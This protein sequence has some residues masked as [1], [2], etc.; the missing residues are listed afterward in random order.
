MCLDLDGNISHNEK[1]VVR[2]LDTKII[3]KEPFFLTF[4]SYVKELVNREGGVL[5]R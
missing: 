1:N 4:F 2:Y 5:D 3:I